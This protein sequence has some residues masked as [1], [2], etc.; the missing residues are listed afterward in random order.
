MRAASVEE[1]RRF[2]GIA[3]SRLR[4]VAVPMQKTQRHQG[5]EEVGV[6][7]RVQLKGILQ[8]AAGHGISPKLCKNPQLDG[9][10]QD[11]GRPETQ[12]NLHDSRWR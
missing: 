8:L 9:G 2:F 4:T 12:A 11:F 10:K 3:I 1:Q 5:I 7:S 6:G